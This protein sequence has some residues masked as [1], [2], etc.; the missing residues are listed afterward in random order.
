MVCVLCIHKQK[1]LIVMP[2]ELCTLV[3]RQSYDCLY[4]SQVSAILENTTELYAWAARH[5]GPIVTNATITVSKF[6]S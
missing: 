5:S 3:D 1:A 2:L 4:I 6:L